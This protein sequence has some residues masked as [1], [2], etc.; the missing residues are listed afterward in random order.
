LGGDRSGGVGVAARRR[1]AHRRLTWDRGF[2]SKG[3]SEPPP[4]PGGTQTGT[5]VREDAQDGLSVAA[6]LQQL[7]G[8][9]AEGG[10][11]RQRPAETD[12]EQ[13][14]GGPVEP[15]GDHAEKETAQG[16]GRQRAPWKAAV[17]QQSIEVE[18]E[19]SA[20]E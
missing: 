5:D 16:V 17:S 4:E 8:L 10:E 3:A 7:D 15:P 6:V 19:R 1:P 13:R 12:A 2:T 11:R 14:V 9:V 20:Q 18:P